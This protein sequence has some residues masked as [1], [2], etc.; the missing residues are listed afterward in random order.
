MNAKSFLTQCIR[1]GLENR[2]LRAIMDLGFL[3]L[4]LCIVAIIL[5][6]I[7]AMIAYGLS[8][9]EWSKSV[10]INLVILMVLA[11]T[12]VVSLAVSVFIASLRV[13]KGNLAR[14]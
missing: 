8:P 7:Y 1:F 2:A 10:V 9:S 4:V 6:L 14:K 3:A 5:V 11:G 12:L 13:R